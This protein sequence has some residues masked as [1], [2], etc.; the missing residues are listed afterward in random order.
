MKHLNLIILPEWCV[1]AG[2]SGTHSVCVCSIHQYVKLTANAITFGD[3][4]VLISKTVCAIENEDCMLGLL[5]LLGKSSNPNMRMG[6]L[7]TSKG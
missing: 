3:C 7:P 6:W 1:L 2:P 5:I 4:A